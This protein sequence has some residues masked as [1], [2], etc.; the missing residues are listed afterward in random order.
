M[1]ED[2]E[3]LNWVLA[4]KLIAR[5]P[6]REVPEAMLGPLRAALLEEQWGEAVSLWMRVRPDEVDVYPSHDFH[7]ADDVALAAQE[8]QFSPLFQD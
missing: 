3:S 8:L 4:L 1:A 2:I 7:T 5:L 6:G